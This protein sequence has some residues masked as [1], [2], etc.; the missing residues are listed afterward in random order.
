MTIHPDDETI[1][2]LDRPVKRRRIL[3]LSLEFNFAPFSGNGVLARS[4]G[5]SLV[6]RDDCIVRV[7][8]AKPHPST[9]GISQDMCMTIPRDKEGSLEIWPVELPQ[10]CQWKRLDRSGPWEE[11]A[12]ACGDSCLGFAS[13]VKDFE[14]T[15]IICVDWH[16]S[17]AWKSICRVISQDDQMMPPTDEASWKPCSA[18]VCYYNFRV[19]SSSSWE[20]SYK[21]ECDAAEQS[22]DQFYRE[23]EQLSCHL[24]NAI[25]CLAEHDKCKIQILIEDRD[26]SHEPIKKEKKIKNVHILHPPLRGD[27]WE[28]ASMNEE[29]ECFH[30]YLPSDARYAIEKASSSSACNKQRLFITC[31]TRLSPEKSPHNF[32]TLLQKLGGIDFLRQNTLIPIICGAR[33]V[34]DYAKQVVDDFEAMCSSPSKEGD[35]AWPCVVIDRNLGPQ[36]LAAVFSRTSVNVHVSHY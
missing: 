35:D 30:R 5:S 10:H 34:E 17:L 19:Y 3:L 32:V 8:C 15:D 36:E 29:M 14:P 24:A 16:G 25:I 26:S 7:V 33:S 28:L 11:Y 20:H 2:N 23:N 21:K 9:P 27:I 31:M 22:D 1:I 13:R 12:S 6:R 4:L 18:I